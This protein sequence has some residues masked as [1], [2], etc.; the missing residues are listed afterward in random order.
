MHDLAKTTI[1]E[2]DFYTKVS[3]EHFSN[4]ENI[5][6]LNALE[7]LIISFDDKN[8]N[9]K[10]EVWNFCKVFIILLF[11]LNYSNSINKTLSKSLIKCKS[12]EEPHLVWSKL[13][14]YASYCDKNSA[15]ISIENFDVQ[16]LEMFSIKKNLEIE[17]KPVEEIDHFIADIALIGSW[18]VENK[19][20]QLV[21]E[22]LSSMPYSSFE[23]KAKGMLLQ[24]PNYFAFDGS[25][26]RIKHK[27]ELLNQ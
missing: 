24:Y 12:H 22:K 2:D 13:V 16:I 3:L 26:W 23:N 7:N 20:D 4:K 25:I 11:D 10:R 18:R 8:E 9:L 15:L 1:D 17:I 19:S 14:E 6:M 27:E 21:I 5:E